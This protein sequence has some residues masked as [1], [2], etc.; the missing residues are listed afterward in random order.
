[1]KPGEIIVVRLNH[2]PGLGRCIESDASRVRV[3]IG[4]NREARLPLSRLLLESGVMAS[5]HE[6]VEALTQ[7]A[8]TVAAGLDLA[9]LWELVCDEGQAFALDDIAGLLWTEPPSPA[10][11]VGLLLHLDRNDLRFS[12][13]GASY[14]PRSREEVDELVARQRRQV[15]NAG[16]EEALA[17]ALAAGEPTPD[18]TAHQSQ[19]LDQLRGLSLFGDDYTRAAAA[20]RFLQKVAAGSSDPQR[21]AFEALARTGLYSEDEFLDLERA[22]IPDEFGD[23]ALAEASAIDIG[24]MLGSPGRRDLT[25]LNIFTIDDQGTE[26]RD[27]GLSIETVRSGEGTASDVSHRIG[28]HI[29]D[30]GSIVKQD[31]VLDRE[32]DRRMSSL[33]LPERSIS[34]LPP[35]IAGDKGSLVPGQRRLGLSVVARVS[36]DGEVLDWEVAPSVL[37]NRAALT[38]PEVDAAIGDPHATLHEEVAA[39]EAI[40]RALRKRRESAGALNLDRDELSVKVAASGDISVGVSRRSGAARSMVAEYMILCNTLLAE[41]CKEHELPAPYRS[42]KA[43]DLGDVIAQVPE[44][45]LRWYLTVRKMSPASI[46]TEP[47]SHGGLGVPAYIQASS[48]LRRYPDLVV[49]RQVSHF[50]ETGQQLYSK[51]EIASVAQ[52]ADVQLREMGRLEEERKKYWFLK[53]LDQRRK[54][55]QDEDGE[56]LYDAIVLDAPANRAGVLELVKY[57]F[58]VRAAFPSTVSPGETVCLRLHGVDLWRRVGQFVVAQ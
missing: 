29:A 24:P 23:D 12:K 30:A 5:G 27:D 16:E 50:V 9:E 43:P 14:L 2:G 8:E 48:P 47:S 41:F 11:R 3:A 13:K 45:P 4:R 35:A 49:Q 10:Q 55:A 58:R 56:S 26:D 52:R 42:Q 7:D 51:E 39:L 20:K 34:M 31:T 1:M 46:S 28:I 6:A 57:P 36:D 19:I 21:S 53:Y 17:A 15:Q 37:T 22:S 38:Y 40:S 18:P 54:A 44:G 32:A 25:H 33:Y